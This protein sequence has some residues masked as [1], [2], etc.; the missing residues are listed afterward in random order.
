M[1]PIMKRTEKDDAVSPVVGVMLMLVVTIIIAAVVA[2]FAGGLVG[3][4]KKTPTAAFD[5]KIYNGTYPDMNGVSTLYMMTITQI[6]GDNLLTK[7]LQLK[8]KWT[9]SAGEVLGGS[10]DGSVLTD[11]NATEYSYDYPYPPVA[12]FTIK[13]ATLMYV[14]DASK[15]LFMDTTQKKITDAGYAL[16]FGN[17]TLSPGYTLMMTSDQIGDYL[18]ADT[19][20]NKLE[21]S[22]KMME[23]ILGS[24]DFKEGTP[25]EVTIIYKPSNGVIYNKEVIVQ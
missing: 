25:I 18:T 16:S 10:Y 13:N 14:N 24:T 21:S 17:V 20:E 9:N 12:N 3:D 5:V 15:G 4:T 23:K 8:F 19:K 11:Y 6:A 7:D 2:A 22:G 1:T